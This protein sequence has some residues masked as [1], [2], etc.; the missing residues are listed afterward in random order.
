MLAVLNYC[1]RVHVLVVSPRG[2]AVVNH[3][4]LLAVVVP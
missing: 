3:A 1:A 4:I 2:S